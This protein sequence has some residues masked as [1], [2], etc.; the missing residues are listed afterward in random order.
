MANTAA[1]NIFADTIQLF[2]PEDT[3]DKIEEEKENEPPCRD[4]RILAWISHMIRNNT[5]YND[6]I[7]KDK[8]FTKQLRQQIFE[9][10]PKN[11]PNI[12]LYLALKK[13]IDTL[14][15]RKKRIV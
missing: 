7:F 1:N 10:A 13:T 8:G 14:K 3:E 9:A 12:L 2:F 15:K 6:Q 11:S 5:N 4:I